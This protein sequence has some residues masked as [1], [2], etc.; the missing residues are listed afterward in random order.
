MIRT[1]RRAPAP[2]GWQATGPSGKLTPPS[3]PPEGL[4]LNLLCALPL[5][6][7]PPQE[8]PPPVPGA[9]ELIAA[10]QKLTEDDRQTVWRGVERR[11]QRETDPLLLRTFGR[12]RG[13]AAYPAMTPPHW[14]LAQDFAPGVAKVRTTA[15]P[16]GAT[17]RALRQQYPPMR[18]LDDLQR[19]VGYD[20]SAGKAARTG[21][22]LTADQHFQNAARGFPPGADHAVA[23]ILE[24]LDTD[25][26]ERQVAAYLEHSYADLD[27]RVYPGVSLYECW[28]SGRRVDVPDV[29][30]IPFARTFVKTQSFVSPIPEG[31]RRERLYQQ[32]KDAAFAHRQ[33]RTLRQAA[34]AAFVAAEPVFDPTYQ[35]LI[36]RFHYLWAT[37]DDEPKKLAELLA[38]TRDR[39]ELLDQ[40]DQ[41]VRADAAALELREGHKQDLQRLA[42]WLRGLCQQELAKVTR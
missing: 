31:R 13:L 26:R 22:E 12:Q 34:A 38:G 33:Y 23:Q 29:D 19:A 41:K 3:P 14:H 9:D 40:V 2:S 24:L 30:A 7:L 37:V 8:S 21:I 4:R 20:W 5:L 1:D 32:I 17:F 36:D 39:Q 27:A 18:C 6:L 16:Q 28:Y 15:D 25:P 11:L 35:P 42:E 10:F